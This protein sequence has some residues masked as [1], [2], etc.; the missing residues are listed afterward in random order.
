VPGALQELR[1]KARAGRDGSVVVDDVVAVGVDAREDAGAAGRA[2]R[3]GRKCVAEV[4]TVAGER[5]ELRGAQPGLGMHETEGVVAMVVG[6]DEDD[7]TA[8]RR[9]GGRVAGQ[10]AATTGSLGD[11][12]SAGLIWRAP[13]ARERGLS[14]AGRWWRPPEKGAAGVAIVVGHEVLSRRGFRTCPRCRRPTAAG[15]QS[16]FCAPRGSGCS[17]PGWPLRT[18]RC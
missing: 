2:E 12:P 16:A 8:A 17:G 10:Q 1:E 13:G 9:L 3:R 6:E 14:A 4:D 7:I 15:A 18:G 5:I 11:V